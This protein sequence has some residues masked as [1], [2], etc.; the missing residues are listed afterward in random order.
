MPS[1]YFRPDP[2][3]VRHLLFERFGDTC[4]QLLAPRREERLICSVLDQ[5]VLE[6][7][8]RFGRH[9]AAEDELG[10]RQLLKGGGEIGFGEGRDRGSWLNSRPMTAPICATSLTGAKRSGR[11]IRES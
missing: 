3:G 2:A 10:V 1:Q 6:G 7:I 8:G 9:A 4:V 5:R 11:A